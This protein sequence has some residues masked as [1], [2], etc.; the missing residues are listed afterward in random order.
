VELLVVLVVE[1]AGESSTA[2]AEVGAVALVALVAEAEAAE[3]SVVLGRLAE[4][5]AMVHET[6]VSADDSY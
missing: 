6:A 3:V 5:R 4:R 2:F 1:R